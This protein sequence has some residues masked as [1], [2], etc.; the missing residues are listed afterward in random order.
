MKRPTNSSWKLPALIQRKRCQ[1]ICWVAS[2][3]SPIL[4]KLK[5][6]CRRGSV[7]LSNRRRLLRTTTSSHSIPRH[8]R[9]EEVLEVLRNNETHLLTISSIDLRK[10]MKT[11][12]SE[13]GLLT[14]RAIDCNPNS[15]K[16]THSAS[17]PPISMTSLEQLWTAK[18][19][20]PSTITVLTPT[21]SGLKGHSRSTITLTPKDK[22]M[23][24]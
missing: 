10:R 19:F 15:I 8:S 14:G 18:R 13:Q 17:T 4:A 2:R 1:T 22:N 16:K 11:R 5:T 3:I 24:E 7:R 6:T 9:T 23:L 12:S 21:S 20:Q